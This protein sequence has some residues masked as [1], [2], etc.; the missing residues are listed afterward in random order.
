MNIPAG[1]ELPG[2]VM[3]HQ[4]PGFWGDHNLSWTG[5]I[6][7][8]TNLGERFAHDQEFPALEDSPQMDGQHL[9]GADGQ[10]Q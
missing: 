3:L 9:T 10:S 7:S 1:Q 8:S 2:T 6:F 5:V 4:L